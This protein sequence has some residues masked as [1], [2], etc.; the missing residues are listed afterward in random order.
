MKIEK[1]LRSEKVVTHVPPQV[2]RTLTEVASRRMSRAGYLRQANSR[3][4]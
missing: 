3:S 4:A 2:A 1:D